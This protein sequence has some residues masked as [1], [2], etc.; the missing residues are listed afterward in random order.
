MLR[1]SQINRRSIRNRR[2]QGM[3]EYALLV[4]GVAIVCV[5]GVSM[6]GHKTADLIGTVASILPGSHSDDNGPI[7]AAQVVPTA[8]DA[9]GDITLDSTTVLNPANTLNNNL[10]IAGYDGQFVD[11]TDAANVTSTP[12]T[13]A[14]N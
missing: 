1:K 2:G 11:D 5:V 9:K 7:I 3:V 12:G 13:S 10:G 8:R 6:M 14:A 4:A